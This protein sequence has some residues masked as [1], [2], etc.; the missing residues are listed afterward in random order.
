MRI[1]V[2]GAADQRYQTL[3]FV[4]RSWDIDPDLGTLGFEVKSWD[5]GRTRRPCV[6]LVII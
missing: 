4:P 6:F 3:G 5:L 2:A 1:G